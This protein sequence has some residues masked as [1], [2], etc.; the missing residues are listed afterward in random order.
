MGRFVFRRRV[1][2]APGVYFD[3]GNER[4][5][6]AKFTDSA[7]PRAIDRWIIPVLMVVMGAALIAIA[8]L[9]V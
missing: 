1:K 2:I 7:Q 8:F 6:Y 9:L 3:L 5:R 4:P